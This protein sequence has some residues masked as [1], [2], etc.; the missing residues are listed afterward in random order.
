MTEGG[1]H[2]RTSG[3]DDDATGH[4]GA[5]PF[6]PELVR[7]VQFINAV[8]GAEAGL[9]LHVKGCVVSGVLISV[10]QYFRMLVEEF[11]EPDRPG[12]QSNPEVAASLAKFYRPA[13]E[14]VE[15]GLEES[16]AGEALPELP[17]HIH[18]RHAQTL[19][20]GQAPM[21]MSL[22]RGRLAEVDGWSFGSLGTAP[23]PNRA[24]D[25]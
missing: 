5:S 20:G 2:A 4:G 3:A 19:V 17:R 16:R 9:T 14:K 12:A 22:W 6:D 10:A 21:T 18:F 15:R 25:L 13:L 8:D 7:L 23:P 1:R 24:F 11:T